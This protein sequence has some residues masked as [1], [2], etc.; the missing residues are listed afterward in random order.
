MRLDFYKGTIFTDREGETS[1]AWAQTPSGIM[2]CVTDRGPGVESIDE[3]RIL[4][5]DLIASL[6]LPG[7]DRDALE[8]IVSAVLEG[9]YLDKPGVRDKGDAVLFLVVNE[10]IQR[11]EACARDLAGD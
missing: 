4:N 3:H 1:A 10:A 8:T 11:V 5:R 6:D 7:L 9:G 2:A